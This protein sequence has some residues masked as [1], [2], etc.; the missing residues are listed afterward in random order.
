MTKVLDTSTTISYVMVLL[1]SLDT[2]IA[3]ELLTQ[4]QHANCLD[5]CS[6]YAGL[7]THKAHHDKAKQWLGLGEVVASTK[8]RPILSWPM[9]PTYIYVCVFPNK[10]Y[11]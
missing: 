8:E 5:F 7:G 10:G 3:Y 4:P 6:L 1:S 2:W 11:W 9:G